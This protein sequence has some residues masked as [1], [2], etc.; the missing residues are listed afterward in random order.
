MELHIKKLATWKMHELSQP[1]VDSIGTISRIGR[2]DLDTLSAGWLNLGESGQ[3]T[4]EL[5]HKLYLY[6]VDWLQSS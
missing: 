1:F 5:V 2:W 4:S 3:L 6:V